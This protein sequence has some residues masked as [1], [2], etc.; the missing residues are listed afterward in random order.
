M[1]YKVIILYRLYMPSYFLGTFTEYP[2]LSTI[3]PRIKVAAVILASICFP[4]ILCG[5][6]LIDS[7]LSISTSSVFSMLKI[8]ILS[9]SSYK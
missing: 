8:Q 3:V 2:M 6:I 7:S 1:A 4:D 9:F 5:I